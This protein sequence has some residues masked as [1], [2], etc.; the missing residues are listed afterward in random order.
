[1][2]FFIQAA[3]SVIE[4]Q[5]TGIPVYKIKSAYL[6][7]LWESYGIQKSTLSD[8]LKSICKKDQQYWSQRPLTSDMIKYASIGLKNLVPYIYNTMSM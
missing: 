7:T 8:Q 2:S 6:S 4:Y 1:M 5:K 3:Y